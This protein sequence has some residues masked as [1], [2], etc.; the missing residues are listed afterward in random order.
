MFTRTPAGDRS[1]V[2]VDVENNFDGTGNH[3]DIGE[4]DVSN[5]YYVRPCMWL[6]IS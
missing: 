2:S 6:D 4:Q 1:V 3:Y 5:S